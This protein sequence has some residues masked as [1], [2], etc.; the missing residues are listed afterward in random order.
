MNNALE[1][2]CRH[3]SEGEPWGKCAIYNGTTF[4]R[5]F[6]S[7]NIHIDLYRDIVRAIR[8]T[9]NITKESTRTQ[10]IREIQRW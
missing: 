4:E 2:F 3:T 7:D 6:Q 10:I 1:S 8:I 9:E 5:V